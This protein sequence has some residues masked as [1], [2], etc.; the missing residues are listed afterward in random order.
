MGSS[1]CLLDAI[2]SGP[3]G[4]VVAEACGAVKLLCCGQEAKRKRKELVSSLRDLRPPCGPIPY[5]FRHLLALSG[6]GPSF[7]QMGLWGAFQ[8]QMAAPACGRKDRNDVGS[9]FAFV[10][11]PIPDFSDF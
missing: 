10:L 11:Y 6:L 1:P 7:G 2:A 3:F 5:K 8:K 4:A 9:S